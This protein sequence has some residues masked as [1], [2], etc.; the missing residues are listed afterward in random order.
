MSKATP[1]HHPPFFGRPPPGSSSLLPP[2]GIKSWDYSYPRPTNPPNVR[3][4]ATSGMTG[5]MFLPH[6]PSPPPKK[7]RKVQSNKCRSPCP[8]G[9]FQ[10]AQGRLGWVEREKLDHLYFHTPSA[11]E[12]KQRQPSFPVANY[13]SHRGFPISR[14]SLASRPRPM[15]KKR[16]L[17]SKAFLP[18]RMGEGA[19]R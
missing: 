1:A 5:L 14:C 19:A 2:T 18:P 15:T 10:P 13:P 3:A 11:G 7:K 4:L 16:H 9:Q 6:I 8:L 12:T 17:V